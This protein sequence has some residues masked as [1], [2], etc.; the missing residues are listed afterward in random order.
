M[1]KMPATQNAELYRL[2]CSS[3]CGVRNV[4]ERCHVAVSRAMNTTNTTRIALQ[5]HGLNESNSLVEGDVK[6]GS[7]MYS[8]FLLADGNYFG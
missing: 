7:F 8:I 2:Y 3:F 1:Q 4:P 5:V 6:P